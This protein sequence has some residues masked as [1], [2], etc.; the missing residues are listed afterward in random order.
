MGKASR[1]K[2]ARGEREAAKAL[3]SVT[4]RPWRRTVGQCRSGS[5]VADVE[6]EDGATEAWCEVKRG[7]RTSWRAAME[8]ARKAAPDGTPCWVLTRDDHGAWV[9]H[10]ELGEVWSLASLGRDAMAERLRGAGDE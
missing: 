5:D 6:R 2:G 4:G 10:V 1:D 8:Q 9:L 3:S 7:K